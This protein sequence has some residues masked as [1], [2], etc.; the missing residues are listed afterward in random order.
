LEISLLFMSNILR[1]VKVWTLHVLLFTI[2]LI[3]QT[4]VLI[5]FVQL[6]CFY[7]CIMVLLFYSHV[8]YPMSTMDNND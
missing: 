3:Q 5:G 8:L 2:V 6:L 1:H 7:L 4:I